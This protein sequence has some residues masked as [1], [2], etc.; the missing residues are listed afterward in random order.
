[1]SNDHFLIEDESVSPQPWMQY[2]HLAA[3]E[4]ASVSRSYGVSGGGNKNDPL[5]TVEAEWTN[6]SPI[7]QWVYG[8]VT[9][10][11]SSVALQARSRGYIV[12][13]HGYEITSGAP[14]IDLVDV[15]RFGIGGDYGKAGLLATGTGFAVSEIRQNS[16][17]IPLMPYLTGWF[18][19][20]PGDTFYA[21]VVLRFVTEYWESTAIS[22]GDTGSESTIISG[23]TRL[24]L[25]AI[26]TTTTPPSRLTPSV[27]GAEHSINYTFAT[28]VDVPAGTAAGD[29]LLAVVCNTFGLISDITPGEGGWAEIHSRDGGW[30]DTHMKVYWRV[31]T[32]SEP[33]SYTFNNALLAEE[34]VQ[35]V[36]IRDAEPSLIDAPWHIA[37][38]V[39][40][41]WW[42]KA[43]G[44]TAPEIN[45][46]GQLL[47]CFS[48]I[49]H[50][51]F[52]SLNQ[53]PPDG[54]TEIRDDDGS[55]STMASAYLY[56]PP[57]PTVPRVFLPSQQPV[58]A[59]KS[60][61]LTI[62][63]PGAQP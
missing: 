6:N 41:Y 54:M 16:T 26:P 4:A 38:S 56:D 62:L 13:S 30:E 7:T 12:Q 24:D 5:H 47:L 31:A 27:I 28:D 1:M 45:R 59:A 46:A 50:Q 8:M 55:Y 10:G 15:S 22:G 51:V 32:G 19:V 20:P 48:Y 35:L 2:R 3:G 17:T 25:Y 34:I 44:N 60:V 29:V 21:K 53:T 11:G 9:R 14:S 63:I 37:S 43:L 36:T 57:R 33:S 39:S 58:W 18:P 49:P 42:K 40:T 52:Q 61:S 23:D